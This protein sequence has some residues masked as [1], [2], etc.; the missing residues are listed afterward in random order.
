MYPA[1]YPASYTATYPAAQPAHH[2]A[3]RPRACRPADPPAS[4]DV[5]A[6]V[7]ALGHRYL[8]PS[9]TNYNYEGEVG[10]QGTAH[11]IVMRSAVGEGGDDA[12]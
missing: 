6:Q 11:A 7:D 8:K 9:L 5:I 12:V 4:D 1:A 2:R 10:G 3:P